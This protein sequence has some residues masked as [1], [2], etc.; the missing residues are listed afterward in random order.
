MAAT[1]SSAIVEDDSKISDV[2]LWLFIIPSV[3]VVISCGFCCVYRRWE[4][5]HILGG[6]GTVNRGRDPGETT[7]RNK[8]SGGGSLGPTP[9]VLPPRKADPGPGNASWNASDSTWGNPNQK[10][11]YAYR[12]GV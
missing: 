12:G 6:D 4:G 1:P 9:Y 11:T 3:L 10:A 2:V 8:G 5:L 7:R